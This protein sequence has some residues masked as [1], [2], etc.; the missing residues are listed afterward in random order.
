MGFPP[1]YAMPDLPAVRE[2]GTCSNIAPIDTVLFRIVITGL[3]NESA[4]AGLSN[5]SFISISGGAC[6]CSPPFLLYPGESTVIHVKIHSL[7]TSSLTGKQI[8]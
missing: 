4:F 1:L 3:M 7:S 6:C 8:N 2:V 5:N